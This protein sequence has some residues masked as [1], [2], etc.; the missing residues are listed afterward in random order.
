MKKCKVCGTEYEEGNL[1]KKRYICTSCGYHFRIPAK[2][3]IRMIADKGTFAEW[4][5]DLDLKIPI[6]ET[7]AEKLAIAREKTGI[8]EAV[9]V[10]EA[11]VL[12]EKIAI[13]VCDSF[14]IMG[15]MGHDYTACGSGDGKYTA[16]IH[17]LLFRR[18]K[19]AGR[20][21]ISDADGKDGCCVRQAR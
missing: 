3:R 8:R 19:N 16:G 4:F 12:G 18:R 9:V 20:H 13:G 14:F 15:S 2:E 1:R 5:E 7:Y 10:G 17:F 11:K 6:E 21:H